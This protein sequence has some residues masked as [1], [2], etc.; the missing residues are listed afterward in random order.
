VE[1]GK[2]RTVPAWKDK[3]KAEEGDDHTNGHTEVAAGGTVRRRLRRARR[4]QAGAI[5]LTLPSLL[6]LAFF[7]AY[8]IVTAVIDSF[9]SGSLLSG[10][11]GGKWVGLANY[12][13]VLSAGPFWHS[14]WFSAL[15]SLGAIVGSYVVGLSLALLLEDPLP[16]RNII[17]LLLLLP[18]II[19]AVVS[20]L[21]WTWLL[22]L[23]TGLGDTITRA[24][25]FGN[26]L[27]LAKAVPAVLTI[28]VVKIWLSYPFMYVILSAGLTGIDPSVNEAAAI[29]GASRPARIRYVTVPLLQDVSLLA[30]TLL[31]IFTVNDFVTP[32]LLTGGGPLGATTNLI[33]FGYNYVFRSFERGPGDVVAVLT[34]L[35]MV[36]LSAWT[37]FGLRRRHA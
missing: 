37:M 2:V 22:S 20:L 7:L 3:G 16:G 25:G 1:E 12:A 35:A 15:F 10:V 28:I 4:L 17:R 18:W 6:L 32:W 30:C 24:L 27:F 21:S 14:V 11:I 5:S 13:S 33:V 19:P 23:T 26:V 31:V 34:A 9:R 36:A 29:D 8:P